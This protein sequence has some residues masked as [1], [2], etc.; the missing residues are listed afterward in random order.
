MLASLSEIEAK[1][2]HEK[3]RWEVFASFLGL[4]KSASLTELEKFAKVLP[5]LL[6]EVKHGKYSPEL[7]RKMIL[8]ELSGGTLQV[9]KCM[10]CGARFVVNKPPE[11]I[12]Y[13]CPRCRISHA[14]VVDKDELEILKAALKEEAPQV[15]ITHK[16]T[17]V[18]Q[19]EQD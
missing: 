13:E 17:P 19:P 7:L 4:V 12:G 14:V 9:L 15:M 3:E 1:V 10:S 16:I 6:S 18:Q 8:K 11:P 5:G 2:H